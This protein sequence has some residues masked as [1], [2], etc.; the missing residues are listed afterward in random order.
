M[1][2]NLNFSPGAMDLAL[3]ISADVEVSSLAPAPK[4]SAGSPNWAVAGWAMKMILARQSSVVSN[5]F[6]VDELIFK[7]ST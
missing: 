6:M 3:L 4:G 7:R 2:A 5:F 1:R